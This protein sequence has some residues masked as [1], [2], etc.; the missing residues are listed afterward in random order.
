MRWFNGGKMHDYSFPSFLSGKSYAPCELRWFIIGKIAYL[1][2]AS[3]DALYDS[4]FLFGPPPYWG[5]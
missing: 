4:I 5:E 2:L 3:C 1:L